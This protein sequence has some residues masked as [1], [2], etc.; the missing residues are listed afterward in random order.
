MTVYVYLILI[1]N[2]LNGNISSL[3][4]EYCVFLIENYDLLRNL[5]EDS[6]ENVALAQKTVIIL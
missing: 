4:P 1:T 2:C 3:T 6:G 5:C